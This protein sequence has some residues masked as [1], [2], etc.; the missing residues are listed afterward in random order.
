MY[1]I[2][3]FFTYN[4]LIY[5]FEGVLRLA[6]IYYQLLVNV[7]PVTGVELHIEPPALWRF[8]CGAVAPFVEVRALRMR[9]AT[10]P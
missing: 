2:E 4:L 7:T 10:S 1:N 8:G 3:L 5:C 9:R 6:I